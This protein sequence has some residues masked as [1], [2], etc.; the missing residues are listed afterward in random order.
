[1]TNRERFLRIMNYQPVDRLP[2]LD[3]EPLEVLTLDRWRKEELPAETD[4]IDFLKMARLVTTGGGRVQ[5]I[6]KFEETIV[7]EEENYFSK[8]IK[9][10]PL[11]AALL[12]A[13]EIR[14]NK[15]S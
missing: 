4:H 15:L 12:K 10:A 6:P 14:K 11:A 1:M 7:S 9:S 13:R 8:P 3:L 2:V 5:P